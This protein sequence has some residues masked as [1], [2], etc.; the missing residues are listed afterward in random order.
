MVQSVF[1][2][3]DLQLAH[4]LEQKKVF[5]KE[6]GSSLTGLGCYTNMAADVSLLWDANVALVKSLKKTLLK[7]TYPLSRAHASMRHNFVCKSWISDKTL[8][9]HTNKLRLQ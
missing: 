9:K 8:Y 6:K 3:C 2:S 1:H 4:L 5:T 7:E